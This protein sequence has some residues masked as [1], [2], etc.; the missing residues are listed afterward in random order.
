MGEGSR[1]ERDHVKV[2]CSKRSRG[3]RLQTGG[4]NGERKSWKIAFNLGAKMDINESDFSYKKEVHA[5]SS[6][7][8]AVFL[9]A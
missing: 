7:P 3:A 8:S 2:T 5:C 6:A 9:L 4:Q 1:W